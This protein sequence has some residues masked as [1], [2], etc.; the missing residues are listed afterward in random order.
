MKKLFKKILKSLNRKR[1]KKERQHRRRQ[2]RKATT[3]K[4]KGQFPKIYKIKTKIISSYGHH[5]FDDTVSDIWWAPLGPIL[6]LS[7]KFSSICV[8]GQILNSKN[9]QI[10]LPEIFILFYFSLQKSDLQSILPAT[11]IGIEVCGFQSSGLD[12][13]C[14]LLFLFSFFFL[15]LGF[16]IDLF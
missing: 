2:N 11:F 10:L 12:P 1:K 4:L 5:I 16:Y 6:Y 8:N 14:F 3:W 9:K 7:F 15:L 13:I